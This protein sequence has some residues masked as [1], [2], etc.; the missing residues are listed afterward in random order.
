[1]VTENLSRIDSFY[2]IKTSNDVTTKLSTSFVEWIERCDDKMNHN[3]R[4]KK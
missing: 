4:P 3:S 2:N 1:M